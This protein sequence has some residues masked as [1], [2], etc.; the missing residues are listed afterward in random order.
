M[1]DGSGTRGNGG[2][3]GGADPS[4]TPWYGSGSQFPYVLRHSGCWDVSVTV[5]EVMTGHCGVGCGVI[6]VS[7]E[8][9]HF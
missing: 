5:R 1:V 3:G 7:G 8:K 2:A 6:V 4:S 9:C